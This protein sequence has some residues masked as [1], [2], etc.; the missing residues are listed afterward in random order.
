MPWRGVEIETVGFEKYFITIEGDRALGF[1]GVQEKSRGCH[2]SRFI[3][4]F[5][6]LRHRFSLHGFRVKALPMSSPVFSSFCEGKCQES[7][8]KN[9]SFED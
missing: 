9:S 7:S 1:L 8:G 3:L 6:A 2:A 4:T 5:A